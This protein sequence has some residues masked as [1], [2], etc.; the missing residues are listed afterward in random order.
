M[1][2]AWSARAR[3]I[4]LQPMPQDLAR[5]VSINCDDCEEKS[6]NLNW[7]FLG[8]QCPKCDSFNT[9][10]EQTAATVSNNSTM[11]AEMPSTNE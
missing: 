7:H 11:D 5:V 4:A 1:A 3:D 10:V 2:S 6:D 8:V 9:V